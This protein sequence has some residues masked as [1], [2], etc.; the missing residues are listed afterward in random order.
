MV[1]SKDDVNVYL[2]DPWTDNECTADVW[3]FITLT[4]SLGA[5]IKLENKRHLDKFDVW[6]FNGPLLLEHRK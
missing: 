1:V 2:P 6:L 5:A 4:S 3:P